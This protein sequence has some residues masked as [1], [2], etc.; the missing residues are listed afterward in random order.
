MT[1]VGY[2]TLDVIPSVRNLKANLEK[3]TSGD[4]AAAGRKGGQQFGDAAGK[5]AATGFRSKFSGGLKGFAPLAG[6]VA[7]AGVV[8]L[9]KDAV[10]GASDLGESTSKVNV[11]FGEASASVLAFGDDS[12]KAFG[13]SEAQALAAAGTFGNLLRS[14]GLNEEKAAQFSTTMVGLA[15]DLASFNNTTVDEALD[16]LRAGLVGETEPLKRFGVNLNDA[17][18]KAKALELGLSD[19]KATLSATAKAQAAYALILKDTALAQGDFAR[20]SDGLANEQRIMAAQWEE[21][22]TSV[23]EKALPA[24]TKFVEVTNDTLIPGLEAAGGAVADAVGAFNDLPTPIKAATGALVAFKVAQATGITTSFATGVGSLSKGL[25][26]VRL[27]GMLAT[28]EFRTLR[29]GTLELNGQVG[30]LTPG[31]GRL[32]ASLGALKTG[33]Q[34]AGGALRSGL[35]GALGILGGPWS[36]ALAASTVAV[37]HFWQE[38]Q[39]AK[40]EIDSFVAT[41]D[42]ETGAFT[43]QSRQA[44]AQKLFDTGALDAAKD[45]GIELNLIT[46]AALG[47]ASAAREL[48]AAIAASSDNDARFTLISSLGQAGVVAQE[49]QSKFELL[50]EA[51][52]DVADAAGSTATETGRAAAGLQTYAS[53]AA[54]ATGEIKALAKAEEKRRLSLIQEKRDRIALLETI[55][56]ARE[57][58]RTGKRTLDENTVAGRDNLTALL[59]LA[60]QWNQS[61]PK[62][63]NAR[64]AY[65]DMRQTF[66]DLADQMN[67]PKGTREAARL[68]AEQLLKVPKTAPIRFK[69]EGYREAVAQIKHLQELSD[70]SVTVHANR[71]F[72]QTGEGPAA[73][74]PT[75]RTPGTRTPRTT[76]EPTAAPRAGVQVNIGTVVA[77]DYQDFMTQA[78]RRTSASQL[79]G[80]R[81]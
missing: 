62:V 43:A 68:L 3:Q 8:S 69:T 59:D 52:K 9:F 72:E 75:P 60:D 29:S 18:L 63:Q 37:T 20:T 73:P 67:G 66:I 45:L 40:A 31:V 42:A 28:S 46:D 81:R 15:S 32:N 1:T 57:E 77:H 76:A 71:L 23:G 49:A 44:V 41:L 50:A 55:A 48:G 30:K 61:S 11:V 58:A 12:A 47:S 64:G 10:D 80:V 17:T 38:H 65:K 26:D 21:L 14:V 35:S 53:R 25:D 2:A 56:A 54:D 13:Q 51:S 5:E 33:A 39:K 24:V 6:L 79:D 4:L 78:Q 16:A 19:G 22:T 27:R 36:L 74:S 70:L 7:G 34:G